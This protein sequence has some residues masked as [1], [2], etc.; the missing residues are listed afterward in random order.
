MSVDMIKWRKQKTKE[1]VFINT[2]GV[3]NTMKINIK[4]LT[5]TAMT[6]TRGSE[7]AAG[8]HGANGRALFLQSFG[9]AE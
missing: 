1:Y 5:D 7:Y 3:Q 4:K 6:P 8:A 9:F 2:Q